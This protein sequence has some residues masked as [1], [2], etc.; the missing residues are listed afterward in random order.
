MLFQLCDVGRVAVKNCFKLLGKLFTF[1]RCIDVQ[2]TIAGTMP[3][4]TDIIHVLN[5]TILLI[6]LRLPVPV[7]SDLK[8]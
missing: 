4:N 1:I 3:L 6:A 5:Y 8:L 2:T 7:I